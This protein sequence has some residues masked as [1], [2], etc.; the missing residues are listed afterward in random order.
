MAIQLQHGIALV[1]GRTVAGQLATAVPSVRQVDGLPLEFLVV[2]A[3]V[4]Q[5]DGAAVVPKALGANAAQCGKVA[6][7]GR[8][9]AAVGN[10]VAKG[11]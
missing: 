7:I 8:Q 10:Q 2:R 1:K 11:Q 4:S 5:F 6:V 9:W 3:K